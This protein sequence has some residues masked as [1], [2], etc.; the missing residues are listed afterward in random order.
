MGP[1]A[2]LIGPPGSGKSTIAAKLATLWGVDKRDTDA[3]IEERAGKPIPDIF[4]EDGEARFREIERDAV[5]SALAEHAGVLA[6]GG[7]AILAPESQE[8]LAAYAADGGTVVFLDV[9][10]AAA[11]PRV[12]LN[13]S[14][15]LL[16]GNP[17]A[18]WV[19]LMDERRPV[20]ERLATVT[21][22]TDKTTPAQV[23]AR[24]DE[25]VKE[26]S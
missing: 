23:A 26:L 13:A 8:L 6:L 20:Y 22:L 16:V 1:R 18:R 5:A 7:G 25:A 14:R 19:A 24:I 10:L 3:D 11:A 12:G 21:V 9:S 4:L 2:V 17:R 15:P